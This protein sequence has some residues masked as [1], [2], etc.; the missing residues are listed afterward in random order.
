MA[1]TQD[2]S[3]DSELDDLL[4]LTDDD[5]LT[6]AA[7]AE[8]PDVS[9]VDIEVPTES[10]NPTPEM[11]EAAAVTVAV[12]KPRAPRRSRAE[13][14]AAR[15]AADLTRAE[16]TETADQARIRELE[17]KL[18]A[19]SAPVSTEP[20]VLNAPALTPEQERI[21]ELERQL[22]EKVSAKAIEGDGPKY[23]LPEAGA[24]TLLIH[25]LADGLVVNGVIT[26]RGQ[27]MEFEVGGPA[28][29]QTKDRNGDT[30]LDLVEDID[31]QFE[32]WGKQYFAPGPWRGKRWGEV[33]K[34]VTDEDAIR[35]IQEAAR[36][37]ARIGRAAPVITL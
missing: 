5:E 16:P 36:K 12:K 35:D 8:V 19:A 30:Y 10:I 24:E 37:Q 25:F 33:P 7:P 4:N 11:E 6:P 20:E 23:I 18:A 9:L 1:D 15:E 31:G 14:E 3:Y 22:E 34:G 2:K 13:M 17:A 27:E 28:Y 32:R 26:Y 29:E 21:A